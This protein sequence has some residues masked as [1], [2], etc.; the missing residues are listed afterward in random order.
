MIQKKFLLSSTTSFVTMS[1]DCCISCLMRL[2]P[3]LYHNASVTMSAI[4]PLEGPST[5]PL[6]KLLP[7]PLNT[8][9]LARSTPSLIKEEDVTSDTLTEIRKLVGELFA[10]EDKYK[11]YIIAVLK[12][13]QGND[14]AEEIYASAKS[15]MIDSLMEKSP[16]KQQ[17]IENGLKTFKEAIDKKSDDE[18]VKD[19]KKINGTS[20]LAYSAA[21]N[22]NND[23][24]QLDS[25]VRRIFGDFKGISTHADWLVSLEAVVSIF[26]ELAQ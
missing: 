7:T 5:P 15:S 11:P 23:L 26:S 1:E 8:P 9:M 21:K 3:K 2:F 12:K 18:R 22:L 14:R 17:E 25:G 10:G 16:E 6:T 19:V 13:Q 4:A 24:H 20:A